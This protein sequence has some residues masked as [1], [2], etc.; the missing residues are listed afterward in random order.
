MYQS[1]SYSTYVLSHDSHMIFSTGQSNQ[2]IY[3]QV[4]GGRAFL[5][6]I[7]K[8]SCPLT[9]PTSTFTIH[10]YFRG[11]RFCSSPVPCSCD[12]EF[13]EGFLLQL[14]ERGKGLRPSDTLSISDQIHIVLTQSDRHGDNEVIGTCIIEWRSV[15]FSPRGKVSHSVELTGLR[16]EGQI[17]PGVLN[18]QWELMPRGDSTLKSDIVEAQLHL[19]HQRMTERKKMFLLYAKQWWK[20]YLGIRPNHSQRLVKIFAEDE[21]GRSNVVCHF[22]RPLRVEWLLD[23]PRHA[24]RF[25]S[26]LRYHQTTSVGGGGGGGEMWRRLHSIL[27][28]KSGV[29]EIVVHSYIHLSIYLINR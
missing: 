13:E 29:S 10:L 11:Q 14:D 6:H 17:P 21:T 24:A 16:T 20:E 22:V 28:T 9:T 26:L 7:D 23:G 8:E 5:D 1:H 18:L 27:A 4:L 19:E 2:C 12:P 15:L 25:V 3:F